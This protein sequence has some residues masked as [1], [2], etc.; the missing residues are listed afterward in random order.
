MEWGGGPE[1]HVF[2]V[3]TFV[4]SSKAVL[5]DTFGRAPRGGWGGICFWD[6]E[7]GEV[8]GDHCSEKLVE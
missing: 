2:E 1:A 5:T 8:K 4:S 7:D 3:A 6:S